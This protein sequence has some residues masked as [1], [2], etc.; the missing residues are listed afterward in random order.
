MN[1][2]YMSVPIIMYCLKVFCLYYKNYNFY[3]LLFGI[4]LNSTTLQ[5]FVFGTALVF[6]FHFVS[7]KKKKIK[8]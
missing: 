8:S 7:K 2:V 3:M 5:N 6:E 1:Y 4:S